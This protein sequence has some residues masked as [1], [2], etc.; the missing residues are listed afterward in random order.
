MDSQ[1]PVRYRSL[2]SVVLVLVL[3][4]A[5]VLVRARSLE[6]ARV[7]ALRLR[8]RPSSPN[9][10]AATQLVGG[11]TS[12]RHSE[13]SRACPNPNRSRRSSRS[14]LSRLMRSGRTRAVDSSP[15]LT[16]SSTSESSRIRRRAGRK[17]PPMMHAA[18]IASQL[19]KSIRAAGPTS[20]AEEPTC[21][22][23]NGERW[24]VREVEGQGRKAFPCECQL[25]ARVARIIPRLYQ[26]A[27]LVDDFKA[28]TIERV[29]GFFANPDSL[30]LLISGPT[31]VGK[32]HL[33][34]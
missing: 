9:F 24:I 8:R 23:C 2:S 16:N 31:G 25:S 18:E 30:G 7:C 21:T 11:E 14:R 13:N 17:E 29:M 33:A 26:A 10:G 28:A 6:N 20:H 12:P 3:V 32:T 22:S 34:A 5:L 15:T 4:L 1:V 27:R 19:T